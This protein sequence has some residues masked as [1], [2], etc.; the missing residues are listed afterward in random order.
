VALA[1]DGAT[2]AR[3]GSSFRDSTLD[4]TSEIQAGHARL[5]MR[6]REL[7]RNNPHAAKA[8]RVFASYLVGPGIKARITLDDDR[9]T[10]QLQQLWD[11]WCAQ[12]VPGSRAG[13]SGL[14]V[15][16][17]RSWWE[18]GEVLVRR[19]I[20]RL[21]DGL[22]VPMQLQVLESDFL[23]SSQTK[24]LA[25]GRVVVGVEFDPLGRRRAYHMRRTHPGDQLGAFDSTVV[26]VPASEVC[27][28]YEEL[29]PGQTRGVP[30]LTSVILRLHEVQAYDEAEL[31]RKRVDA[32]VAAFVLAPADDGTDANDSGDKLLITDSEGH[33]LRHIEPGMFHVLRGG[34]D[35]KMHVPAASPGY[36]G[37]MTVALRTIA[38]GC[39]MP[40]E[41]L[42]GDLSKVNYSSLQFGMDSF[43]ASIVQLRDTQ[44]VPHVLAPTWQ[45]FA[46]V[47]EASGA[48]RFRAPEEKRQVAWVPP[49][50]PR[51]DR[52]GEAEAT[53]KELRLGRTTLRRVVAEDG[54]DWSAYLAEQKGIVDDLKGAGLLFDSIPALATAQGQ[55][56]SAG[57]SPSV[58]PSPGGGAGSDSSEE[59]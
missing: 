57:A 33:T 49:P 35:V 56:P 55:S 45:W 51:V 11:D 29:R 22:P 31:T 14:Q 52:K 7:V 19:R 24:T 4:A 34:S 39:D 59:P 17:A 12:C 32:C 58:A 10:R 28:L 20:R 15:L 21:E 2:R 38:A 23:D 18:S 37:Y 46:D 36:E 8:I 47:A 3:R 9:R 44:L 13:L 40:Y 43:K 50:W 5:L 1:Y 30:F 26:V 27:H 54:W 16:L 53:L 41:L 6:S 42:S 48:F 25:D